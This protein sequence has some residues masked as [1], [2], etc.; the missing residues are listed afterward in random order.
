[1][2]PGTPAR[3]RSD[4]AMTGPR[5]SGRAGGRTAGTVIRPRD[6]KDV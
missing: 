3:S 4:K 1:M 5:T 6:E 2:T